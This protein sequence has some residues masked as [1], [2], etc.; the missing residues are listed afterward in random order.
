MTKRRV[1]VPRFAVPNGMQSNANGEERMSGLSNG[2]RRM[3]LA[4]SVAPALGLASLLAAAA[5]PEELRLASPDGEIRV[6]LEVGEAVTWRIDV[7]NQ[8]LLH[9]SRL[10]LGIDGHDCVDADPRVREIRR[11]SVDEVLRPEIRLKSATVA[12]RYN[13]LVVVFDSDC[14]VA[15]RAFDN[16]VAYRFETAL[17]GEITVKSE[18]FELDFGPEAHVWL[19]EENDFY[20][21][22]ERSY[23]HQPISYVT[24]RKLASTPASATTSRWST[25]TGRSP[26]RPR[27]GSCWSTSTAPTSPPACTAPGRT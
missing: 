2:W 22:N 16:G 12:N 10:A 19:P 6:Q 15:V 11:N 7:A 23:I 21:H 20:S 4:W 14:A 9:P 1:R 3:G 18:T 5:A 25:S 13:E 17:P 26:R 8:A 24:P 27:S